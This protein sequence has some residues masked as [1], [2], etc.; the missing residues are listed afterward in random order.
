MQEETMTQRPNHW[1]G[2]Q[3][4]TRYVGRLLRMNFPQITEVGL[5]NDRNVAGTSKKSSHAEGRAID[6]H[7]SAKNPD[8]KALADRLADIRFG[9]TIQGCRSGV[10]LFS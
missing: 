9:G 2:P 5:Y 3:P 1:K 10:L 4:A 7:L 6:F 8:Q